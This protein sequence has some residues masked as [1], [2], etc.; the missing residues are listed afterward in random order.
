MPIYVTTLRNVPVRATGTK[1]VEYKRRR[2]RGR[3]NCIMKN[4]SLAAYIAALLCSSYPVALLSAAETGKENDE[5]EVSGEVFIATRGGQNFKLGLVQISAFRAE[6]MKT[7]LDAKHEYAQRK[8]VEIHPVLEKAEKVK[9]R[10]SALRKAVSDAYLND[11]LN[12]QLEQVNSVFEKASEAIDEAYW[13]CSARNKYL[14]SGEMY[15]EGLPEPLTSTKTNSDGKFVLMLPSNR[16]YVLAAHAQRIAGDTVEQYFW[17]F[18]ISVTDQKHAVTFANDN[19]TSSGS[20][21]SL[22]QTVAISPADLAREATNRTKTQDERLKALGEVEKYVGDL[23]KQAFLLHIPNVENP[24]LKATLKPSSPVAFSKDDLVT[25]T[26]D[27]PLYFNNTVHR[28]GRNGEVFTVY[29]HNLTTHKVFVLTKDSTGKTIALSVKDD[30]LAIQPTLPRQP[31]YR[32]N[33]K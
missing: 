22:I 27:E 26:R 20:K 6:A 17:M 3:E 7:H 25:L 24:E 2:F 15:F 10:M 11:I 21:D 28:N 1:D 32:S 4:L 16:A 19:L 30:A 33:E 14:S 23:Q 5:V 18:P 31:I 9:A 8:A 29:S 12:K 13:R